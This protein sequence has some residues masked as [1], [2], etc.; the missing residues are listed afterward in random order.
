MDDNLS[1]DGITK[2]VYLVV[3]CGMNRIAMKNT[4]GANAATAIRRSDFGVGKCTPVLADAVNTVLQV[5]VI[6]D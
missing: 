3:D 4:C 1:L 6:K 5:E 2:P